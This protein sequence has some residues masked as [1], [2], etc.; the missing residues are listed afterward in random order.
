MD[1]TS[2][3]RPVQDY[4][5]GLPQASSLNSRPLAGKRIGIIKETIGAGVAAGVSEAF[6]RAARHLESL[7]ADV[8]EV[9]LH[10]LAP[11]FKIKLMPCI[12]V[13]LFAVEDFQTAWHLDLH[14]RFLLEV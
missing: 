7:G 1:A 9:R 8:D 4:A 10:P 6:A 3:P 14:R 13:G 5:E 2:S 12:S 11:L